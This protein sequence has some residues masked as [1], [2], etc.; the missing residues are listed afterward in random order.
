[1]VIY[2]LNLTPDIEGIPDGTANQFLQLYTDLKGREKSKQNLSS[3][4]MNKTVQDNI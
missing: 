4:I 2:G 3:D 1:M